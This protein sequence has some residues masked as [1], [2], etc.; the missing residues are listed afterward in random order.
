MHAKLKLALARYITDFGVST[1]VIIGVV[2]NMHDYMFVVSSRSFP[3]GVVIQRVHTHGV[4]SH[5]IFNCI[6]SEKYS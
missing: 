2:Y 6:Q 3:T 5:K 1:H 4:A